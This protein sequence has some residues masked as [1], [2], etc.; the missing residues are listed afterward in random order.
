MGFELSFMSDGEIKIQL[1]KENSKEKWE[2][3][4]KI[5]D[6]YFKEPDVPSTAKEDAKQ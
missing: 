2:L 1:P 3:A 4:K 6:M 5:V